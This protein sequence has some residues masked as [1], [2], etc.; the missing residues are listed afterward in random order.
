M[1]II[2]SYGTGRIQR[3]V[4]KLTINGTGVLL[5]AIYC[6]GLLTGGS[7]YL[8]FEP[9]RSFTDH[10]P[11]GTV[12]SFHFP[13][14][15]MI[16]TIISLTACSVIFCSGLSLAGYPGIYAAPYLIGTISGLL[17]L[18]MIGTGSAVSLI[19]FILFLPFYSAAVCVF[20]FLCEHACCMTRLLFREKGSREGEEIKKYAVRMVLLAL[21]LVVL[22]VLLCLII[23]LLRQFN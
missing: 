8:L 13:E 2:S 9:V 18:S 10:I 14:L 15:L 21:I 3:N 12:L 16:M 22:N 7:L 5:T 11:I 19:K 23:V 6:A 17:F 4:N 1:R 20:L